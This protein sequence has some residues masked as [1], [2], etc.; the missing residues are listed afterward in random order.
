MGK[1]EYIEKIQKVKKEL[2]YRKNIYKILKK[3]MEYISLTGTLGLKINNIWL[4]LENNWNIK[5]IIRI[6]TSIMNYYNYHIIGVKNVNGLIYYNKWCCLS[7]K[8]FKL[9]ITINELGEITEGY[10]DCITIKDNIDN[11]IDNNVDISEI[12]IISLPNSK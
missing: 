9:N 7:D 10:Y 3:N 2:N 4:R 5:W 12:N 1:K 11:N 8:D 6:K